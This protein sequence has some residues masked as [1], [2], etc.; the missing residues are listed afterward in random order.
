MVHP[1]FAKVKGDK[2]LSLFPTRTNICR[3][4]LLLLGRKLHYGQFYNAIVVEGCRP[5]VPA[6]MPDDYALLM[7][8]CGAANGGVECCC[9]CYASVLVGSSCCWCCLLQLHVSWCDSALL[10]QR[11]AADIGVRLL[12]VACSGAVRCCNIVHSMQLKQRSTRCPATVDTEALVMSMLWR[13]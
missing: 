5:T 1:V 7:Q 10:L 3:L 12:H 9:T 13:C 11:C 2:A 4:S 6:D 8:K